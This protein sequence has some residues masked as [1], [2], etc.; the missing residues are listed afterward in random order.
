MYVFEIILTR[1]T[2]PD[3]AIHFGEI[4]LQELYIGFW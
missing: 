1:L 4:I 3:I 2:R